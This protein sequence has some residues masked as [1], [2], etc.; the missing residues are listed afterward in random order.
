[1]NTLCYFT[2]YIL[3]IYL[4]LKNVLVP[5]GKLFSLPNDR[6]WKIVYLNQVNSKLVDLHG[7]IKQDPSGPT[8]I[9]NFRRF[10]SIKS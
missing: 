9:S 6:V 4:I 5:Q 8:I 2:D 1:M 7:F 3:N 10:R